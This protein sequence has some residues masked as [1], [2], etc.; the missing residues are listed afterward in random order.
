VEQQQI[1]MKDIVE[2]LR[3]LSFKT[4]SFGGCDKEDVLDKI[5]V[6]TRMYQQL[7][8]GREQQWQAERDACTQQVEQLRE[9]VGG[10]R[11]RVQ[12]KLHQLREAEERSKQELIETAERLKKGHDEILIRARHEAGQIRIR[13]QQE[14]QALVAHRQEELGRLAKDQEEFK[15]QQRQVQ[16]GWANELLEHKVSLRILQEE[17]RAMLSKA[18]ELEGRMEMQS[19]APQAQAQEPNDQA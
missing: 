15:R 5:E 13:A 8:E 10:E 18:G 6:L 16:E 2:Y 12:D 9:A 3:G 14:A 4:R 19:A 7:L 17:L 11:A 1:T